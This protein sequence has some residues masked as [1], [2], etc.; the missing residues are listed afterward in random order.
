MKKPYTSV[1]RSLF[2]SLINGT[3]NTC[4]LKRPGV[5]KEGYMSCTHPHMLVSFC[6]FDA[7]CNKQ[8]L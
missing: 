6:A 4:N 3:D 2:I 8:N 1:C 7:Q 5:G